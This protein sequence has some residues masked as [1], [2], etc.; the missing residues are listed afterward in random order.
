MPPSSR[1]ASTSQ[2]VHARARVLPY[3]KVEQPLMLTR[4]QFSVAHV[5]LWWG[6]TEGRR[7][8]ELWGFEALEDV[9]DLTTSYSLEGSKSSC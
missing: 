6:D 2:G 7:I 4:T 3:Q 9:R 1:G 8:A 5:S